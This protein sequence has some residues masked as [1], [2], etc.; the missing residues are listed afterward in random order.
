[1]FHSVSL[2]SQAPLALG[3]CALL[4]V[5]FIYVLP[6]FDLDEEGWETD[7]PGHNI[8]DGNTPQKSDWE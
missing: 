7:P 1:M 6:L 3:S 2:L 8:G 5:L 4:S